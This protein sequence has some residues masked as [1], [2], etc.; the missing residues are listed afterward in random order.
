M[1]LRQDPYL[2]A[3]DDP[4]WHDIAVGNLLEIPRDIPELLD[5][6]ISGCLIKKSED[7]MNS[8]CI[9]QLFSMLRPD[10]N[11]IIPPAQGNNL[12]LDWDNKSGHIKTTSNPIQGEAIAN[13]Q[14]TNNEVKRKKNTY[15]FFDKPEQSNK[16][17]KKDIFCD[18][19][20]NF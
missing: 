1:C 17:A 20:F 3:G 5:R 14:M 15:L 8:K 4:S 10:S 11:D 2:K 6:I 13:N 16:I 9:T 19:S 12:A 7:R 18:S